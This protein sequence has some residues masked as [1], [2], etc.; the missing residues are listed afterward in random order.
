MSKF[1]AGFPFCLQSHEKI[2]FLELRNGRIRQLSR[3]VS[4]LIYLS[5]NTIS[6]LFD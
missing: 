2:A 1:F 6:Q 5:I 4:R 3:C